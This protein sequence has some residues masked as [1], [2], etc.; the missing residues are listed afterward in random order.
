MQLVRIN[1]LGQSNRTLYDRDALD[2]ASSV[3]PVSARYLGAVSAFIVAEKAAGLWALTDD[4]GPL[5]G[6]NAAQALTSLKQRRLATAVNSPILTAGRGY[7]FDAATNCIDTGFVPSTHA[8]AMGL[9]SIHFEIYERTE[10][11]AN[12]YAGG[13]SN[14]SNRL[15]TIRPR[16][17]SSV[18]AAA[19]CSNGTFTLSPVSSLGL[20]QVGR[21]GPAG[22]DVYCSKNGVDLVASVVPSVVGT[23]LPVNSI[24]IGALSNSGT[25]SGFRGTNIGFWAAGAALGSSQQRLARYNNVQAFAAAVGAQV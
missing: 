9:N 3:G 14:A 15:I 5:W 8:V 24:L 13:V 21:N 2:W 4:Y 7:T 19:G 17:T 10:L 1:R 18:N 25:A 20:T 23:A 11:S 16:V 12:S 6:E 22:S